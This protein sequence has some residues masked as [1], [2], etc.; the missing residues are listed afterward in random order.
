MS[1]D[2]NGIA[3]LQLT[4]DRGKNGLEFWERLCHFLNMR[5]LIKAKTCFTVS[6]AAPVFSSG[7]RRPKKQPIAM[8]KIPQDCTISALEPGQLKMSMRLPISPNTNSVSYTHL[9]AHETGA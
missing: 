1:I 9:R 7:K 5:T 4:I 6:A 3:H 8:I 2:I